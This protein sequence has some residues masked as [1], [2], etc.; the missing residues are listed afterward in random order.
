MQLRVR[1]LPETHCPWV[2][3][4]RGRPA[5]KHCGFLAQEALDPRGTVYNSYT[6]LSSE[7]SFP[8]LRLTA[9]HSERFL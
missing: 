5:E 8:F 6:G 1:P 7:S 4:A 2:L 9:P 3:W